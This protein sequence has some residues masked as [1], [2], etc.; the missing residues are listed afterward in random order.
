MKRIIRS[1]KHM[2]VELLSAIAFLFI[3][4]SMIFSNQNID[5]LNSIFWIILFSV[6]FVLQ[7]VSVIFKENLLLLRICM[8]WISGSIWTWVSFSNREFIII[9]PMVLIGLWNF[10]S[11]IDLCNRATFDWQSLLKE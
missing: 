10:I 7:L 9:I 1:E 5:T 6:F 4:I 2:G 8:T 3:S 11:F